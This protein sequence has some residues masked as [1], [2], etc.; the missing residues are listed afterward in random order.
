MVPM[1]H[2]VRIQAPA[3]LYGLGLCPGDENGS[4]RGRL[5]RVPACLAVVR[6]FWRA[7]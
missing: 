1:L 2:G 3:L 7:L 5:G 6:L 4:I